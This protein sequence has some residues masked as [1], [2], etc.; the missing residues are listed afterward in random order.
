M[1]TRKGLVWLSSYPKSGNT[2]F[3]I[4]LA[5]L[6]NSSQ[7][8]SYINDVDKILGSPMVVN[9]TWVNQ[10]LGFDSQWLSQEEVQQ[11]RPITYQWYA[12]KVEQITYIKTHDAYT[13]LSDNT[14]VMP[15]E[16]CLGAVYF[17]R[18]PLDVAISLSHH[19]KC[20]IDWSIEMMGNPHF[21]VPIDLNNAKQIPQK[22]LS[23]SQHVQ[24]W[25][26]LTAMNILVLRYE[27]LFFQP[28]DTFSRGIQFLNVD[29]SPM[30]LKQAIEEAS[31]NTL[32]QFEARFG[33]REKPAIEG[34]FFRKGIVGDW[35]NTLNKAQIQKII[36]DHAEVMH[37]FGY[38]D[39]HMQPVSCF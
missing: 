3:R 33:F 15:S 11:L 27:D 1:P 29:V 24:S 32:Q 39:E 8:L 10:A 38:L 28:F 23:W 30:A 6:L 36:R 20:P 35:K 17:I 34:R 4:F 19:A 7:H 18:N 22:L 21:S 9:R 13:Y 25:T 37:A 5:R 12:K 2:W 31:F 26:S 14:P 16:G